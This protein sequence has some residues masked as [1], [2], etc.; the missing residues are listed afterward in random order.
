M[1]GFPMGNSGKL[2]ETLGNFGK[3]WET[4]GNFGKLL[5]DEKMMM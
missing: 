5:H 2:W 3:L 1:V 4:L